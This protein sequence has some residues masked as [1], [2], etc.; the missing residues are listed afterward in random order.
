LGEQRRITVKERTLSITHHEVEL[1]STEIA[2]FEVRTSFE[3]AWQID[4]KT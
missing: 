2:V 3:Y 4:S 1:K